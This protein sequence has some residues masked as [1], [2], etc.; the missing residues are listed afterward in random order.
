[1]SLGF[2]QKTLLH[3]IQS[4]M[5]QDTR[6]KAIIKEKDARTQ[7]NQ[8][9]ADQIKI[10][11][12]GIIDQEKIEIIASAHEVREVG[13]EIYVLI[14]GHADYDRDKN[15]PILSD[16]TKILVDN[17]N[18]IE[19]AITNQFLEADIDISTSIK[20]RVESA[21]PKQKM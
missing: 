6:D 17:T 11:L 1:V 9:I 14:D 20:E 10:S 8:F 4:I 12:T 15:K 3:L 2:D 13:S 21:F 16:Q 18:M 5:Q 7:W 19:Y